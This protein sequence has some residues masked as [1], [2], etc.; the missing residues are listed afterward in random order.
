[1]FYFKRSGKQLVTTNKWTCTISDAM[2]TFWHSGVRSLRLL[3]DNKLFPIKCQELLNIHRK[4]I[5]IL[6]HKLVNFDKSNKLQ[7]GN[8]KIGPIFYKCVQSTKKKQ[9]EPAE[10][11]KGSADSHWTGP[12]W[13]SSGVF[14]G[15]PVVKTVLPKQAV[16]FWS[17]TGELRS[18][19]LHEKKN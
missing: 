18:H 5:L 11:R 13:K 9:W 14:P 19:M 15:G 16:W 10:C 17:L 12:L 7:I 3:F 8:T 1:M 4:L 6:C 2:R